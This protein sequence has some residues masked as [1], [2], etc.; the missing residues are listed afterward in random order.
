MR[1]STQRN[2]KSATLLADEYLY[3]WV[4]TTGERCARDMVDIRK[5]IRQLWQAMAG[6]RRVYPSRQRDGIDAKK[7]NE[8]WW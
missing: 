4:A 7:Y 1:R 8:T 2:D 3:Y 6:I 5:Q